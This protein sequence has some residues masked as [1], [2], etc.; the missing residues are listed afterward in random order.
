MKVR[1]K[2]KEL[3]GSGV[4]REITRIHRSP[5]AKVK[6]RKTMSQKPKP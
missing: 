4:C 5:L 2:V 6:D 1:R 3:R